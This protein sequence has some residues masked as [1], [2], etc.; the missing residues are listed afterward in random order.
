MTTETPRSSP[1]DLDSATGVW[2]GR[3]RSPACFGGRHPRELAGTGHARCYAAGMK[4]SILMPVFNERATL[5]SAVKRVLDVG[6]PVDVELVIVD[7]GSVD[8]T[9][10]LYPQWEG[11]P[12]VNV[13]L[14]PTNGGKGSAIRKGDE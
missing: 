6:Y 13:H 3:V 8:G 10:G 4:L 7:D 11:D 14:K 12:R 1:I 9:R 5:E 2:V